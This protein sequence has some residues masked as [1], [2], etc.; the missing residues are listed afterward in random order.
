MNVRQLRHHLFIRIPIP[1]HSHTHNTH[2]THNTHTH[3]HTHNTTHTPAH[4]HT[5]TPPP[6][7]TA[8][9]HAHRMP[10][11]A[12]HP[13]VRP[14]HVVRRGGRFGDGATRGVADHGGAERRVTRAGRDDHHHPALQRHS[15]RRRQGHRGRCRPRQR[16]RRLHG[17]GAMTSTSSRPAFLRSPPPTPSP[18]Q[19]RV[20]WSP[21]M[22]HADGKVLSAVL[23]P[24]LGAFLVCPKLGAPGAE[25]WPG[26]YG[27][28]EERRTRHAAGPV[29]ELV[30]VDMLAACLR[31]GVKTAKGRVPCIQPYPHA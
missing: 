27:V 10:I 7:H 26:L 29:V 8:C 6:T 20:A 30:D 16:Q 15:R 13:M 22:C 18:P 14:I 3:T 17:N 28:P 9:P 4:T 25:E 2:N 21:S 31:C 24:K 19:R 1:T 23:C 12:C 11:D 5:H